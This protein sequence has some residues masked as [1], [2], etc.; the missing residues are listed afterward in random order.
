MGIM[1]KLTKFGIAKKVYDEVRKPENKAKVKG[2]VSKARNKSS[3]SRPR[4]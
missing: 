3:R 4:S 2:M 1:S